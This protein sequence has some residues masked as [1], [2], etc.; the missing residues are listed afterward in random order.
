MPRGVT[1]V[2]KRARL[3]KDRENEILK[4]YFQQVN[5]IIT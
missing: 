1:W 3:S 4:A 5:L 2:G